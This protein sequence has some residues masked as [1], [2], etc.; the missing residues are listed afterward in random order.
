MGK[1][2]DLTNQRF[3]RLVVVEKAFVKN[4]H[5]YWRCK[6][7]CGKEKEV[8]G[9]LL[10]NGNTTSCGCYQKERAS[11]QQSLKILNKKFGLLTVI[12]Q[13]PNKNGK[14]YWK[15]KC[16]CG[17][18]CE[19][20]GSS[21]TS[22]RVKSCGCLLK[23]TGERFYQ[24]LTGQKF[25]RLTVIKRAEDKIYDNGKHYTRFLCKCDCG[26][27]ILVFANGLKGNQISC[28]CVKRSK[29]EQ[30]IFHYLQNNKINFKEQYQ[31]ILEN[32]EKRYFDFAILNND[33]L[34]LIEFDGEQHFK[35]VKHF[36]KFEETQLHDKQKTYWAQTN[37]IPL[38]RISYTDYKNIDSILDNFINELFNGG[39]KNV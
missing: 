26:K 37:N 22:G 21:L 11:E 34:G 17:N 3:G 9:S 2:I 31:I 38:L 5:T 33:I 28:G 35:E 6:C 12:E 32:N 1:L 18:Y 15:C 20:F 19:K 30:Q 36:G 23:S 13:L 4:Q 25:D 7:D 24:D 16:E 10:R 8:R 27:E 14:T 39:I 29:G